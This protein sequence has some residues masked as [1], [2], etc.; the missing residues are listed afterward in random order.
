MHIKMNIHCIYYYDVS[1]HIMI[2]RVQEL[3]A[4]NDLSFNAVI[5]QCVQYAL[6]NMKEE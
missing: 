3:A 4:K 1:K 2:E 6:D 5:Q